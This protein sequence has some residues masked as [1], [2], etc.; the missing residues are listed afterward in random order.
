[1][2]TA[3]ICFRNE[4]KEVEN[5]IRSI[6]STSKN[7]EIMLCD[8]C[9]DD[10][11]DYKAV[12]DKYGCIYHRMGKRMGSAGTKDWAGRNCPTDKFVI[13]DGHMRLYDMYWDERLEAMLNENPNQIVS[14]RTSYMS[15]NPD[16]TIKGENK[17]EMHSY[18]A[19]IQFN[20]GYDYDPKWTDKVIDYQEQ[21]GKVSCVLGAFYATT[22]DWWQKIDGLNG[23]HI[24]G[25]EES[26][27][28]IKTWLFGGI[29]TVTKDFGVGHLY[30]DKNI[31][32]I[33]PNDIDANRL[34]LGFVFSNYD[35]VFAGLAK[36][37]KG[38][39][40][41]DIVQRF[42][43]R[44]DKAEE[45]KEFIKSNQIHD[46]DWFMKNVNDKTIM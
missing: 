13:M 19:Y 30:R 26:F 44:I 42:T 22:K 39:M 43:N 45:I 46:I 40:F 24:Y 31:N 34:F 20:N 4:G 10:G 8:D 16:G 7:V 6:I 37:I 2:I 27:M 36:R 14:S 41:S 17:Y 23:L 15:L 38:R 9:S 1:M 28:S 11:V 18:C 25:L 33:L 21:V 35:R 12:A 29:C 5:T 3:C 32:H